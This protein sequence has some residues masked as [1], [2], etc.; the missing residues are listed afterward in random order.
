MKNK[1]DSLFF[2]QHIKLISRLY[3][4]SL[5]NV[6]LCHKTTYA[7]KSC[8][9]STTRMQLNISCAVVARNA[10]SDKCH[11][12]LSNMRRAVFGRL[13]IF[14][15]LSFRAAQRGLGSFTSIK[16]SSVHICTCWHHDF[17]FY[18]GRLIAFFRS[19]ENLCF[20][21]LCCYC[22]KVFNY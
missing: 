12:V 21:L 3:F 16:K 14:A 10:S 15:C 18:I 20:V 8:A 13:I 9:P 1:R 4:K 5:K 6:K 11:F 22:T 17:S 2:E 7:A 19:P